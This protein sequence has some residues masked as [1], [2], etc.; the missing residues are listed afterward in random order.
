M[1]GFEYQ[2]VSTTKCSFFWLWYYENA[3]KTDKNYYDVDL[4]FIQRGKIRKDRD[5]RTL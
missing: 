4:F 2:I 5:Y 3:D 1:V